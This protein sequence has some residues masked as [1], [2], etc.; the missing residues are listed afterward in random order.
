[1]A[2]HSSGSNITNFVYVESV[3]LGE[4]I[5]TVQHLKQG[6]WNIKI[7]RGKKILMQE[8]YIHWGK[9][10]EGKILTLN[11]WERYIHRDSNIERNAK[12]K[13]KTLHLRDAFELKE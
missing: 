5:N 11:K 12:K 4:K 10:R 1:M 13:V 7:T 9:N 6:W 8:T 2:I 3:F